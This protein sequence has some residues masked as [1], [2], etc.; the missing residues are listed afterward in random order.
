MRNDAPILLDV[1]RLIWRQ[2]ANV[3]P[4]GID[5]ICL[6]WLEHFAGRAQAVVTFRHHS[7]IL[8]TDTSQHVFRLLLQP[9]RDT[10]SAQARARLILTA[11]R[12]IGGLLGKLQ[13]H[14]RLWLN[15]GHTGLDLPGLADWV[16]RVDVRPVMMLHDIIPITHSQFCRTGEADRHMR[17]LK[18]MLR[19][20]RGIIGNS[21]HTIDELGQLAAKLGMAMPPTKAIWP[22]TKLL[23][24]ASG[25]ERP[26]RPTFIILGTVEGRKN[27]RLLLD[28]WD[29]LIRELGSKAPRLLII[30]RRGWSSE[31]VFARLDAGGYREHIVETGPLDDTAIAERLAHA[32][33]LLFPS[34]AEGYGLPMVEALAAGVPVIASDLPVFREIGQ[35]VPDLLDPDDVDGWVNAIK[36]YSDPHNLARA[37]QMTRLRRFEG[38]SWSQHFVQV[39]RFLADLPA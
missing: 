24:P 7:A 21:Q 31:D 17:R 23:S 11:L 15:I 12:Q 10:G 20:S 35:T 14:G 34:H 38:P 27:H 6:A 19:L 36:D 2:W 37:A 3:R 29:R 16:E 1:S 25:T 8:P 9:H 30:G 5:R 22:G 33:A 18:T 32:S 13:G 26:V 28:V 4:T 39:E